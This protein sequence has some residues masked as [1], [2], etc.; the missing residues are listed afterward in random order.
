MFLGVDWSEVF[1]PRMPLAEIFV[2]G[3]L[4]YLLLFIGIR[5]LFKRE[6]GD[7]KISRLLVIVLI[8]DAIQNGM[9]GSYTTLTDG[10]LLVAVII[11]WSYVLD[12]LG[13][14]F[15]SVRR[16]LHP[17][18]L[19]LVKDG[20]M[21]RENMREEMITRRELMEEIRL[22]GL[23]EVAQVRRMWIEGD[24]RFSLLPYEKKDENGS[25]EAQESIHSGA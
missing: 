2:R 8:A 20:R 3:S 13:M 16:F 10:L 15:Q 18:S 19:L 6:T 22:Q 1:Q 7:I 25:Q 9:A 4:T 12:W 5:V 23:E 11:G 21:I 17:D 14:R 24:G